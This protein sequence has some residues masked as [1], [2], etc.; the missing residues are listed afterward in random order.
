MNSKYSLKRFL[1]ACCSTLCILIASTPIAK[2]CT[3]LLVT[4]GASADNSCMI[5]Y[6][7]DSAGF[8]VRLAIVEQSDGTFIPTGGSGVFPEGTKTHRVVGFVGENVIDSFQG[9]M[10]DCQVAIAETTWGGRPELQNK[11]GHFKY[12]ELM[13]AALQGAS[14]A[15]EAVELMGRLVDEFG[16]IDEGES[17][18][19]CDKNEAWVFEICGTGADSEENNTGCVWVALRV[20][21]GCITAHANHARIGEFPL[22]RPEE[23]VYSKNIISFATEKGY[24][25]PEKDGNFSFFK[26][27][28]RNGV[29]D[30]RVCEKRV[31]SIFRRAAPSLDL[32]FD[33]AQGEDAEPYPWSIRP[34]SKLSFESVAL[35]MRDHFE[36]TEFDMREGGD[37]GPY[38]NPMRCRPLYWNYDGKKYAWERPISTQQTCFSIITRSTDELPDAVGGLVWF[39][40]DDTYTTC[41]APIYASISKLP[42]STTMGS[43]NRFDMKSGW[44]TYN[45]VANY[46]YPRYEEMI[47][48]IQSKQNS[49][50]SYFRSLQKPVERTAADL[51]TSDLNAAVQFLT[52]YSCMQVEKARSEW[53]DLA[54][55]LIVKFNDGYSKNEKGEYPNVGYPE[56][57]LKRVVEE[58]GERFVL[59]Q[60]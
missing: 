28:G 44:W 42:E 51:V 59:P 53:E 43:I 11:V 49:L 35:L 27:Y 40:W 52:D 54:N 26:T 37:A 20:P 60:E 30:R 6:T 31:W 46:A 15:R 4:K 47:P 36:G 23:C 38:G 32:P 18:S 17:I 1:F 8:F 12:P 9:I 25:N 29:E 56:K 33:Y 7:A 58:R 57:W 21:D 50:E 34:D 39:G 5:T 19:V 55:Q 3:S 45:F 22:D 24:Y 14:T 13:T 48:I 2:A 16:Y 10:N 41:Y